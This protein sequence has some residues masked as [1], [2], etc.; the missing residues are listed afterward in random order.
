MR[1]LT[2]NDFSISSSRPSRPSRPSCHRLN[3]SGFRF[4]LVRLL[5]ARDTRAG[6]PSSPIDISANMQMATI[7]YGNYA[8][9]LIYSVGGWRGVAVTGGVPDPIGPTYH[10]SST[11]NSTLE[12]VFNGELA[13]TSSQIHATEADAI[14][15]VILLPCL[16]SVSRC[17][18]TRSL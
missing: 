18:N 17:A 16:A 12:F 15:Q 9:Q 6:R 2:K 3:R 5:F 13:S 1:S 10:A 8:S 7:S 14:Y 11:F 4:V